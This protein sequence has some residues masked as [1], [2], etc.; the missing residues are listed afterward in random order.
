[1]NTNKSIKERIKAMPLRI[2]LLVAVSL[3][4]L[5]GVLMLLLFHAHK[6]TKN[7]RRNIASITTVRYVSINAD[8]K[9]VVRILPGASMETEGIVDGR[10]VFLPEENMGCDTTECVGIWMDNGKDGGCITIPSTDIIDNGKSETAYPDTLTRIRKILQ[11][12]IERDKETIKNLSYYKRANSKGS[13]F[14]TMG[15]NAETT[16]KKQMKAREKCLAAI[17]KIDRKARITVCRH[18]KTIASFY[19]HRNRLT[20]MPLIPTGK[21]A[22]NGVTLMKTTDGR[23]PFGAIVASFDDEETMQDINGKD[24]IVATVVISRTSEEATPVRHF[25][26]LRSSMSMNNGAKTPALTLSRKSTPDG[27]AVFSIEGKLIGMVTKGKVTALTPYSF[28]P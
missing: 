23:I 8:G 15:T 21:K 10:S 5:V 17:A 26:L 13:E 27:S 19:N 20:T 12:A 14:H 1:M 2:R 18:Q 16:V 25:I 22:M 28:K 3:C 6:E 9:E 4:A 7:L 24:V 11:K